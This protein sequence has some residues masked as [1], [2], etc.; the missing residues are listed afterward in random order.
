[1]SGENKMTNTMKKC[2]VAG[3]MVVGASA[4]ANASNTADLTSLHRQCPSKFYMTSA[5]SNNTQWIAGV[6]PFGSKNQYNVLGF[7]LKSPSVN[8]E[9]IILSGETVKGLSVALDAVKVNDYDASFSI[10]ADYN[11]NNYGIGAVA[12]QNE[13]NIGAR[14]SYKGITAFVTSPVIQKIS[15]TYG[16]TADAKH[17]KVEAS[18]NPETKKYDAVISKVFPS[19]KGTFLPQIKMDGT[20]VGVA[21]GYIPGGK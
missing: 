4:I 1:M 7:A 17:F 8:L 19:K 3:M 20:S 16:I 14:A 9:E 18:Y 12:S 5:D 6:Q 10:A 11:S 13:L 2:I 21:V 15:P